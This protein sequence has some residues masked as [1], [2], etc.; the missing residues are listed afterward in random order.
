MINFSEIFISSEQ[1]TTCP[2]CGARTEILLDFSHTK[3]ETQIHK[4]LDENCSK[5]FIVQ[6]DKDFEKF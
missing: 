6:Q 1:P 2:K 5:E 4:C 3:D